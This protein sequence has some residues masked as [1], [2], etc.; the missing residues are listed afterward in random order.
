MLLSQLHFRI[1]NVSTLC[2]LAQGT[3]LQPVEWLWVS[4]SHCPVSSNHNDGRGQ[5]VVSVKYSSLL[6]LERKHQAYKE[7]NILCT[8]YVL[9]LH[10]EFGC[11]LTKRL[12]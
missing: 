11:Y 2:L 3:Y 10:V 5:A 4:L 6:G 12:I 9:E 7:I 8:S 1:R